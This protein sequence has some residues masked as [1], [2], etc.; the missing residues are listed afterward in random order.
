[1][2]TRPLSLRALLILLGILLP[3]S[4]SD[5]NSCPSCI[6]DVDPAKLIDP[7]SLG[8]GSGYPGTTWDRVGDVRTLGWSATGLASAETLAQRFTS[9]A[10]MVVDRGVVVWAYGNT[11]KNYVVQ[12]CR[13]SF[14]SA[15]YG[16]FVHDGTID[17]GLTVGE[18]GID[19]L[20]PSLT[21]EEKGATL[22]NLI[23]ARS[24]VYHEAAAESQS[25][26]DTRPERGSHPPG[27]FW[28]YNNWDFNVLGTAF[29]QLTGEDI[30]ESLYT[31]FSLPLQMQE[32]QPSNGW[33]MYQEM[34]EHPAYHF[35]M[36]ARDMA[37]FGL[38][39]LREGR[40]REQQ[41]VPA[42]WV[43]RSVV[44]YSITGSTLDYGYMWW[45]GRPGDW[46]GYALYAALGGSGQAIFVVPE[47]EVVITHKVDYDSWQGSWTN[48]YDL[49]REILSAKVVM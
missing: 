20:P 6:Q 3:G 47:L 24:G 22:E 11:A 49:V 13:K 14:L 5:G 28:Y 43:A 4:C 1:M 12:S 36:S 38:L 10:V 21:Q 39:F 7:R 46:N 16:I 45:V 23:M 25:M 35:N 29:I 34:S 42:E 44:P 41:I 9:D 37:R 17:L 48:V 19:D 40:W 2:K 18:L 8:D 26:K 31:R 33:Y 32:F 30:F 27:A 15:L